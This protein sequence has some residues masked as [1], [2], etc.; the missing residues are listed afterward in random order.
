M[1]S[2][3]SLGG[4]LTIILTVSTVAFSQGTADIV[5]R[6]TDASGAVLPAVTVTAENI[7][8]K[9]IRTT[10]STD[11]GDYVFTLL[12]IGAYTVKIE[13]QGFQTVNTK[14]GPC[15]GR[16]RA[17]RRED[18]AG[19]GAGEPDRQRR[20]PTAADRLCDGQ[21]AHR[22]RRRCRMLRYQV[23]TS[24]AWCSSFRARMKAR[25]A[26]SPTARGP[27]SAARPRRCPSTAS[28]DVLNNQLVDGM[29]NNERTIGTVA[30][31]PSIDAIAEVRVQT[32]MYTAETGRTLGGV[33]NIITKSGGNQF[34]GSGFEFA[35]HE[36]FDARL[37]FAQD[38]PLTRQNQFGGSI[39]GPISKDRTFFFADYEG[40]RIKQGVPSVVTVPTVRMRNGDFS[41]LSTQIYDPINAN[42]DAVCGQPDSGQPLRS[43][44]R[45]VHAALP[46]ADRSGAGQQLLVHERAH[47]GQRRDRRPCRP[48]VRRSQHHLRAIFVQQDRHADAEPVPADRHRRQLDRPDVHRRRSGNR[49]LRGT[50]LHHRAQRDRQLRAHPERDDHH[51]GEGQLLE[52]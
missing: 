47:P 25:S 22:P 32:N 6:V 40:Y 24:S 37:F 18:G 44:R 41:E 49:Q 11:T 33:I 39:G 35:R 8:T 31:K 4:A 52:A 26:R 45:Q 42:A 21:L 17:R 28:N 12:P 15:D 38:K 51:G 3:R 16:P 14:R 34:H 50:E 13:L 10:V 36:R 5:G 1:V 43:D 7:A 2:L 30:I 9:S 23:G 29:D 27:T 46:D 20:G 48:P 19:D